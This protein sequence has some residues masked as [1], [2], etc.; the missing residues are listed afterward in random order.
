MTQIKWNVAKRD[1]GLIVSVADRAVALSRNLGVV[2]NRQD[3]M[4]DLTACHLNGNSLDLRRLLRF[5]DLDFSHDVF[6]IGRHISHETGKMMHC[7][8]PKATKKVSRKAA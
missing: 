2:R 4:M 7:F 6:G 5:K 8:L 3:V 1:F